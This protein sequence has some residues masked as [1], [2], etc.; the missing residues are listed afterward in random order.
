MADHF[1]ACDR[2]QAATLAQVV[3]AAQ[4]TQQANDS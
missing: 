2:D 1:L 4:L 3:V